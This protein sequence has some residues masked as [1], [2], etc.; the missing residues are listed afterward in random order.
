MTKPVTVHVP[1]DWTGEQALNVYEL[2]HELAGGIWDHY[3][4]PIIEHIDA[5]A[6]AHARAQSDPPD[7][8]DELPF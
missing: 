2:L 6:R 1:D 5:N 7:F 3:E 4:T 8:D